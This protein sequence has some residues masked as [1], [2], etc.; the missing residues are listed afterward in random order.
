MVKCVGADEIDFL[1][2]RVFQ[3][4]GAVQDFAKYSF[5]W[6]IHQREIKSSFLWQNVSFVDLVNAFFYVPQ[7]SFFQPLGRVISFG[8]FVESEIFH[9]KFAVNRQDLL[10][11]KN[12][13]IHHIYPSKFVLRLKR[14]AWQY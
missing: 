7:K 6:N 13:G 12:R 14:P 5:R 4:C 11:Y 1:T 9:T 3:G 10:P 2:A 8:F